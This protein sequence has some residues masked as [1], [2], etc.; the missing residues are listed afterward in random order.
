MRALRAALDKA[1]AMASTSALH[2]VPSSPA[3]LESSAGGRSDDSAAVGNWVARRLAQQA[4]DEKVLQ[5]AT[6]APQT[7]ASVDLASWSVDD[8]SEWLRTTVRF[9]AEQVEALRA[10]GISG[11]ELTTLDEL[12]LRVLGVVDLPQRKRILR[13]L[14]ELR[15]RARR[16]VPSGAL[17]EQKLARQ[18]EARRRRLQVLGECMAKVLATTPVIPL[19]TRRLLTQLWQQAEDVGLDALA[20]ID[21]NDNVHRQ[22]EAEQAER[23]R[24]ACRRRL[25]AQMR[26]C[27]E[28]ED[29]LH[30]TEEL[31]RL[32][33]AKMEMLR[34][35][36]N[37]ENSLR[38]GKGETW[39]PERAFSHEMV[40]LLVPSDFSIHEISPPEL[41]SSFVRMSTDLEELVHTAE[42]DWYSCD[43]ELSHA[44]TVIH[45]L[46]VESSQEAKRVQRLRAIS[47]SREHARE[48]ERQREIA[49]AAAAA[50]AAA[51]AE[52]RAALAAFAPAAAPAA[53][54]PKKPKR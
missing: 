47:A 6:K 2:G 20:Q 33:R 35:S 13:Q 40:N 16:E 3:L 32:E 54:A 36:M 30:E 21:L 46:D 23:I 17:S 52:L 51:A 19:R 5:D 18:L 22:R 8:V 53:V 24:H 43:M 29:V 26:A 50:A 4:L 39:S 45:D 27:A 31:L 9:D 10:Q 25:E 14:H 41:S 15:A 11:V 28:A 12:D 42:H 1:E 49:E 38:K 7:G 34:A 48:R 37:I 44:E